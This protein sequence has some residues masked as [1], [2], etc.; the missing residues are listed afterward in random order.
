[1]EVVVLVLAVLLL[2]VVVAALLSRRRESPA[3]SASSL[4]SEPG[5]PSPGDVPEDQAKRAESEGEDLE[6]MQR[7]RERGDGDDSAADVSRRGPIAGEEG[8]SG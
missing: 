7:L 3:A 8:K 4:A 2:V 6:Q 5:A 1:M